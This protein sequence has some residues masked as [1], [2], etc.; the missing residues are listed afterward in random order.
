MS[1]YPHPVRLSLSHLTMRRESLAP[2]LRDSLPILLERR[3]SRNRVLSLL[4]LDIAHVCC[5]AR[6]IEKGSP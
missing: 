2:P 5:A 1:L 4:F 3:Q 6:A